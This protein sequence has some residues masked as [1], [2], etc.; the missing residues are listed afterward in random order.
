MNYL[1]EIIEALQATEHRLVEKALRTQSQTGRRWD[2]YKLIASR[3]CKTDEEAAL[4]MYGKEPSSAFCHL[5]TR[6]FNNILEVIFPNSLVQTQG[7]LDALKYACWRKMLLAQFL[8]S[9][10]AYLC[11]SLMISEA[12]VIA[13][14]VGLL[15]EGLILE[16]LLLKVQ[17]QLQTE[18]E[19]TAEA[20]EVD[21]LMDALRVDL[22]A[23][24]A[25][26][27]LLRLQERQNLRPENLPASLHHLATRLV[28]T[29]AKISSK[30]RFWQLRFMLHYQQATHQ[31]EV[32]TQYATLLWQAIQD[33]ETDI[34]HS[35]R[36]QALL[37][38]SSM[39]YRMGNVTVARQILEEVM[40]TA[41]NDSL[42]GL[43]ALEQLFLMDFYNLDYAAAART[44]QIA[45]VHPKLSLSAFR[46]SKWR[47]YHANLEFVLGNWHKSLHL[48]VENKELFKYKSKW[49][50]GLK[51]LEMYNFIALGER[52][53]VEYKLNA[54]KQLLKRQKD[55]DIGRCKYIC[56]RI[57]THLRTSQDREECTPLCPSDTMYLW[58]PF[59]F[60][61][62]RVE[63]WQQATL[64][65]DRLGA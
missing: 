24:Q 40:A 30:T 59:N 11:G 51:L 16:E 6:L 23:K 54:L 44:L 33:P 3:A 5:K 32:A 34:A 53:L 12:K 63:V 28:N 17:V 49:L 42:H 15:A 38:I 61:V 31:L 48:I 25:T 56:K 26:F 13:Q 35:D 50:L 14:Q 37:D 21:A 8:V 65:V 7:Q 43:L 57:G 60:E 58:T 41:H 29:H 22:D 18:E 46:A 45:L 62:V 4:A 52:E 64:Q 1:I 39:H 55:H 20:G 19:E 9:R 36:M 2:L 10:E 27:K 47:Y